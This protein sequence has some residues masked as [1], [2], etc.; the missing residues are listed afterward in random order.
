MIIISY[1]ISDTKLRNQFSKYICR[2][3]YRLQFSV[4]QI[5]HSSKIL[6]NVCAD[7]ENKFSKRFT[8]SD[9]VYIFNLSKNCKIKR[10]GYAKHEESD[11]III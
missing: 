10:Y 5:N 3:G 1:D 6:D 11:M 9:S 8:E 2:F 4:Y 7:I